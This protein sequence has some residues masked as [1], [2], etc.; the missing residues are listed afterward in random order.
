MLIVQWRGPVRRL[1]VLNLTR[2]TFGLQ[3]GVVS[4]YLV[5]IGGTYRWISQIYNISKART[6]Q[7]IFGRD[8]YP[9]AT[10]CACGDVVPGLMMGS[11][12][13]VCTVLQDNRQNALDEPASRPTTRAEVERM[14]LCIFGSQRG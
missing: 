2:A 9:P 6:P 1:V 4:R 13:L 11:M 12:R 14:W 10:L 5:D 7:C 3:E 8:R